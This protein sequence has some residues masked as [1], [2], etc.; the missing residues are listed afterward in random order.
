MSFYLTIYS[1]FIGIRNG[2]Q[3][4]VQGCVM[5]CG[6]VGICRGFAADL[7]SFGLVLSRF[8]YRFVELCLGICRGLAMD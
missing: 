7:C 4:R 3:L 8:R 2:T 1:T 5:F 6:G